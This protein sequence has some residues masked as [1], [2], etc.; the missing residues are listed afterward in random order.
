M[1]SIFL[2]CISMLCILGQQLSAHN[3]P[4]IGHRDAKQ[5][6]VLDIRIS[7]IQPAIAKALT[8][9]NFTN[10][11][12]VSLDISDDAFN[13]FYFASVG[14]GV[15]FQEPGSNDVYKIN[16]LYPIIYDPLTNTYYGDHVDPEKV[17]NGGP[18][19]NPDNNFC[20]ARNCVGCGTMRDQN[21]KTLGCTPC[22]PI[23]DDKPYSCVV[24]NT[25]GIGG[26]RIISALGGIIKGII[27]LF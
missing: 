10:I 25:S 1:K 2:T 11:K 8:D 13:P 4:A 16:Y 14:I 24:E 20:V 27:S 15:T 7:Q 21:G 12:V 17:T 5:G 23:N 18:Q 19:G 6:A 3:K 26:G 9:C 22:V